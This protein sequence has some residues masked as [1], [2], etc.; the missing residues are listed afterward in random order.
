MDSPTIPSPAHQPIF[1]L[2]PDPIVSLAILNGLC[3]QGNPGHFS[4][5]SAFSYVVPS[6]WS[7]FLTVFHP[8]T[9]FPEDLASALPPPGSPPRPPRPCVV[10]IAVLCPLC[11]ENPSLLQMGGRG[12]GHLVLLTCLGLAHSGY[13]INICFKNT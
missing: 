12:P 10:P 9:A 11:W 13:S 6:A 8:L 5:L 7:I 4:C 1:A 2:A 3:S